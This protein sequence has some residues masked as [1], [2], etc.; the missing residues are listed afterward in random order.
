[1][2][3][4]SIPDYAKSKVVFL[5]R[6]AQSIENE[7]KAGLSDGWSQIKKFKLPTKYQFQKSVSVLKYSPDSKLSRVGK[8][9]V[10]SVRG[11]IEKTDF[12]QRHQIELIVSSTLKRS[13]ETAEGAFKA[14]V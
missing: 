14:S 13:R 10:D 7:K 12:L 11:Q 8:E 1:M 3:H 9:Q 5:M 6:H 2:N 4:N